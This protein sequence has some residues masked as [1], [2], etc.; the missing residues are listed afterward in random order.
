MAVTKL[1]AKKSEP[2]K[3]IEAIT[4]IAEVTFT[5]RGVKPTLGECTRVAGRAAALLKLGDEKETV[6][7]TAAISIAKKYGLVS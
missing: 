7:N 1:E 4:E 2:N 5:F 3:A 6:E